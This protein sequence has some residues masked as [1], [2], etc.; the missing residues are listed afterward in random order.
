MPLKN[1][2][3]S[4]VCGALF[5]VVALVV[6]LNEGRSLVAYKDPAGILTICDGETLGVRAGETRTQAQCDAT[7]RKGIARHATA[8]QGLPESLPDAVLVGSID[9]VYNIGTN[10]FSNSRVHAALAV[11]DYKAAGDAVLAWRYISQ[12]KAPAP[13]LGWTYDGKRWRFDCS[14]TFNGKRNR[15]C[16]GLWERRQWQ[17]KAIGNQFKTV[18]DAIAALPK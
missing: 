12:T 8:L 7:L 18:Q 6:G 16:W 15:V 17:S 4:K 5:G 14:Q 9:L 10:G 3:V 2:L 11:G 13:T 1:K